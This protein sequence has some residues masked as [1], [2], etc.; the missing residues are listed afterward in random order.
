MEKLKSL[1]WWILFVVFAVGVVFALPAILR[2]ALGTDTPVVTITSRSMWPALNRGDLVFVKSTSLE[3]IRVG[4]VIVFRHEAGLALHRVVR[5]NGNTITTKGDANTQED[6]PIN[7][8]DVVGRVPT[9]GSHLAKIPYIGR[10]EL[11]GNPVPTASQNGQLATMPQGQ[12]A[13]MWRYLSSPL[14]IGLLV[15]FV[16]LLILIRL[17]SNLRLRLSA[18]A[19]RTQRRREMAR[20]LERRWGK[21]PARRALRL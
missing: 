18:T 12:V 15:I 5:V 4:T 14:V 1:L 9:I 16:L 19:R 21:A 3:D 11:I 7:Y 8:T 2:Y 17:I 13:R 6:A 20:R 10:I